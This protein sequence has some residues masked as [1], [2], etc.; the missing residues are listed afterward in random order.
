[1]TPCALYASGSW[2]LRRPDEQK[3]RVA[4]RRMLRAVLGKGRRQLEQ[5]AGSSSDSATD[6]AAVEQN[7]SEDGLE[8]WIDWLHRTTQEVRTAMDKLKMDDWV[9]LVRKSQWRWASKVAQH[10]TQ[11]WTVRVLW[12]QPEE[13]CRQVGRPRSRWIDP[14][15]SFAQSWTGMDDAREALFY[16]LANEKEA[17]KALPA[18]VDHCAAEIV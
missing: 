5:E 10:S 17:K 4:Q 12:W 6:N 16:L 18:Y 13:G 1:M 14:L 11:R 2:S 15:Q 8:T 3:L 9:T 7:A